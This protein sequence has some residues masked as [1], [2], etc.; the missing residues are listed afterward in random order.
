MRRTPLLTLLAAAIV[1]LVPAAA[2]AD[3]PAP[4]APIAGLPLSQPKQVH[5]H[6]GVLKVTFDAEQR[7]ISVSGSKIVAQPL[8]DTLVG[9][10]LHVHPGDTIDVTFINATKQDTNFHFHGMH[11]SP[12]GDGDNVFRSFA[13]NTTVHSRVTLPLDHETGTYWY[14]A[15][16]HGLTEPQ[17][18]GGMSGLIV[19]EGLDKLLPPKL[20]GLREQQIAIRDLQPN[21]QMPWAAALSGDEIDVQK[22]TMRLVNGLLNPRTALRSGETQL[23]RLAN[24]GSDLFYDVQLVGHKFTVI[25]EDGD[26]KWNVRTVDHLVMP[27]GKRFDVLVTGGK[28]GQYVFKTRAYHRQEGFELLPE[29]QLMDVQV[30]PARGRVA[31]VRMPRHLATQGGPVTG[32]PVVRR[33]TFTFSFDFNSPEFARI[34][35][36]AF[37]PAKTNVAPYVNTVEEWTLRNVT[38][39]DHP[40]HIHVNDFQVMRVNGKPYHASG[41]QDVVII[42]H[43]NHGHPGTVVI[44]IPFDDYTG[45]FVFHCHIL[46][47]EDGGMMMTVQVRKK[48]AP[49][50]PPPNAGHVHTDML[51]ARWALIC[52]LRAQ[53]AVRLRTV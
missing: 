9:P 38:T 48:G 15:H 33:R 6:N 13:P 42:P 40:F 22:P 51:S 4:W 43:R 21:P 37:N 41:L 19:V 36:Q 8:G 31:P 47:H 20:R 5:A 30:L 27:P 18:M 17:V 45:H 32:R 29:K 2:H 10:T 7:T 11:V 14:H 23:W 53:H 26:P 1:A 39:E 35:G 34:N 28:P 24:I 12:K 44:R 46:S 3:D 50:T 52:R 25:G 16:F 49:V